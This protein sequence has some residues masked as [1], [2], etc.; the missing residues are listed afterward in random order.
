MSLISGIFVSRLFQLTTASVQIVA[1]R[2]CDSHVTELFD[3]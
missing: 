3:L 1:F 2:S